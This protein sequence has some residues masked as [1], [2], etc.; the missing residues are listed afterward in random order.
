MHW[1]TFEDLLLAIPDPAY[2]SALVAFLLEHG[3]GM[4][5]IPP[6]LAAQ[7]TYNHLVCDAGFGVA[8]YRDKSGDAR[9][10]QANVFPMCR[11][12][13]GNAS[14]Y[15]SDT[16]RADTRRFAVGQM[17][18]GATCSV[19][20]EHPG[21]IALLVADREMRQTK[22]SFVAFLDTWICAAE[23]WFRT[24]S[25]MIRSE[26]GYSIKGLRQIRDEIWSAPSKSPWIDPPHL[27]QLLVRWDEFSRDL[28]RCC[29]QCACCEQRQEVDRQQDDG[30]DPCVDEHV[31]IFIFLRDGFLLHE[32]RNING[33]TFEPGCYLRDDLGNRREHALRYEFAHVAMEG[34]R[35]PGALEGCRWMEESFAAYMAGMHN[36]WSDCGQSWHELDVYAVWLYL[37]KK[38]T[39]DVEKLLRSYL[40]P[41]QS[42]TFCPVV[43]LMRAT[44]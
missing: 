41:Q 18:L 28:H 15:M 33:A 43:K 32:P 20:D 40:S 36:D 23:E 16:S 8:V 11:P 7:A 19:F 21:A 24:H 5:H 14:S 10:P 44:V 2:Q 30:T 29:Q 35:Q 34:V 9:C 31:P 13:D 1:V 4:L 42:G 26:C 39:D 3:A 27:A 6:D 37:A 25:D 22:D 17:T 38:S 12:T